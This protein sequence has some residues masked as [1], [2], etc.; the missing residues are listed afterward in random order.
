M[1][2]TI[3]ARHLDLTPALSDYIRKKVEKCERYFDHLVWAQ[4]ILSV[5]K[6][7]QVAEIVIHARRS[8]FR[9]QEE[10]IDLYAAVDLAVDKMEMQLRKY[11]EKSKVHR[12]ADNQSFVPETGARR[13]KPFS[14]S[15]K[16]ARGDRHLISEI[17]RFDVKPFTVSEA[18]DEMELLGYTFYLFFNEASSQINV[19]YR[20]DN[21]SYGLLEPRI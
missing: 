19:V 17:R 15:S 21:G 12:K 1:Q 7:R 8:T 9:S 3:T 11:K 16:N 20:R 2:I 6:Y 10:S 4:V 18:I 5:E 14:L 13:G